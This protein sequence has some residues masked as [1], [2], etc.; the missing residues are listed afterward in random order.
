[1]DSENQLSLAEEQRRTDEPMNYNGFKRS[2]PEQG[3]PMTQ[4][5]K[6]FVV[7]RAA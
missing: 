4:I 5:S 7:E 6:H 3:G 1:M 2:L